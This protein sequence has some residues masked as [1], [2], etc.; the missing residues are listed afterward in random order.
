MN[1][2]QYAHRVASEV[3]NQ[4]VVGVYNQLACALDAADATKTGV[5]KQVFGVLG[6]QFIKLERGDRI[7]GFDVVV[8]VFA[9]LF[10][11]RCPKKAPSFA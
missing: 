1:H 6:K 10:G 9:V 7:V 11:L 8:N 3:V 4:N 5:R 2:A